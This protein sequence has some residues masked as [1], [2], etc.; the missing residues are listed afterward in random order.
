MKCPHCRIEIHPNFKKTH[1]ETYSVAVTPD[2]DSY[3]DILNYSVK[4]M[5]CPNPAC[6]KII[7][8]LCEDYNDGI[9][10]TSSQNETQIFPYGI[11]RPPCPIEVN[12]KDIVEDYEEAC[13]VLSLSPKASAALSRRCL[14]H[15][16]RSK[17]NTTERDLSKQIQ[18]VIDSGKL[19]S[20][21]TD[22]IDA[23]RN[24]GNFAA[25][26]IKDKSTGEILPVEV[27][28]AEWN[29]DVLEL[30]FDFYYVQP[31]I[32]LKKKQQLN[33]KLQAAGKPQMK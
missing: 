22:S 29:L 15:L 5:L 1:L 17:A 26:P 25:H 10:L 4:S 13:K 30:L 3:I 6:S 11:S 23:I 28:E 12:D 19:P 33:L 32:N 27:G 20:H 21:L 2:E 16:L 18:E 9:S 31:S 8:F 7:I 14:Q 24:I